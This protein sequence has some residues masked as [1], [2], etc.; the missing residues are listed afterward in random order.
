[1][2]V[3][4]G[5]CGRWFRGRFHVIDKY[6]IVFYVWVYIYLKLLANEIYVKSQIKE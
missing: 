4:G 3:D 6:V 2:V 1:M 5:F